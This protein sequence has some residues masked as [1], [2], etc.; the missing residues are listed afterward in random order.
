MAFSVPSFK[1][2][3]VGEYGVGKTSLFRR[4]MDNDFLEQTT[5]RSNIGLDNFTKDYEFGDDKIRVSKLFN[6]FVLYAHFKSYDYFVD[7][8]G[9]M[10]HRWNRTIRDNVIELLPEL[11]CSNSLFQL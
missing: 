5:P 10:G 1:V 4:F 6:E 2:I 7:V 9:V 11:E 8:A 3:L